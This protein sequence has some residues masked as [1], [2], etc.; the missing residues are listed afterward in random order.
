M[1]A[2]SVA[3]P[4][5]HVGPAVDV[6]ACR[7]PARTWGSRA[8]PRRTVPLLVL[9]ADS[10]PCDERHAP[11]GCGPPPWPAS[12]SSG[13]AAQ[14]GR[15]PPRD[16]RRRGPSRRPLRGLGHLAARTSSAVAAV[17]AAGETRA[18]L[19]PRHA[20]EPGPRPSPRAGEEAAE[21]RRRR[22]GPAGPGRG[23]SRRRPGGGSVTVLA[24]R[25][26]HS[27]RPALRPPSAQVEGR[28]QGAH[29]PLDVVLGARC[30][31]SGWSRSRSCRC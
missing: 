30:T 16:R 4:G 2:S 15:A 28:V 7:R 11:S 6:E 1:M 18:T 31:T 19:R 17:R 24:W 9:R 20:V 10:R 13:R 22:A 26:S 8:A 12:T 3:R 29:R 27:V 23:R 21:R 14:R 25:S 5:C